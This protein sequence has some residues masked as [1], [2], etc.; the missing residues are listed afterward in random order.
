MDKIR[1]QKGRIKTTSENR[2]SKICGLV[3][4]I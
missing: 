4:L 3:L 1:K 2:F